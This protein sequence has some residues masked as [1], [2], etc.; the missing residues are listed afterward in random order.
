MR[1]TV[2]QTARASGKPVVQE[3]RDFLA[4]VPGNA[5]VE[6]AVDLTQPVD[7]VIMTVTYDMETQR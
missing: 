6:V 5:L 2:T 1:V 4:S 7:A 3:L